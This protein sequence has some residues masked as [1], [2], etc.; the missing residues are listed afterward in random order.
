MIL[1]ELLTRALPYAETSAASDAQVAALV[2]SKK[3]WEKSKAC[4]HLLFPA[5]PNPVHCL[6]W[7]ETYFG[8]F[9][10]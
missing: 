8:T 7:I 9:V 5:P 1:I 2:L 4:S 3:V 10:G 6:G